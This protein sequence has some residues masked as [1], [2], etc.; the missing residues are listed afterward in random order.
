M[1]YN[2]RNALQRELQPD[3]GDKNGYCLGV[4][5]GAGVEGGGGGGAGDTG[6]ETRFSSVFIRSILY[7]ARD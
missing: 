6:L 5:G 4:R 3:I 1:Y 7:T 2:I